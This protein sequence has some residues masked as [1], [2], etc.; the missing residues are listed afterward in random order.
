MRIY[1]LAD[2]H[3]HLSELNNA[4]T[5]I[6]ADEGDQI[7]FG[8]DYVDRG[9]DSLGVLATVREYAMTH[10]AIA[11]MGNHEEGFL[12]WI[13]SDEDGAEPWPGEDRGFLTLR[14]FLTDTTIDQWIGQCH[15][16]DEDPETSAWFNQTAKAS[17]RAQHGGLINWMRNLRPY[18]E[19]NRQIF[20]HAGVDESA[21]DAWKAATEEHVWASKFPPATGQFIKD[22]IAGHTETSSPFLANDPNYR[23][24]FWDGA[25]HY[26]IDGGVEATGQIPVLIYDTNTKLYTTFKETRPG[27]WIEQPVTTDTR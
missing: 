3:G 8:G 24:V 4:L 6:D 20:V 17:I 5:L 11:L 22:V 16:N 27:H 23:G 12:E 10:G 19:T 14:S 25:S 7:V 13:D 21:G 2:V 9:P 1:A 18:Y 15:S 26:Y